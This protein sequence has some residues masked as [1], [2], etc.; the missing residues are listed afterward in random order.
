MCVLWCLLLFLGL[1]VGSDGCFV[2]GVF[3]SHQTE[4]N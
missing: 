2:V 3:I 1:M 4:K